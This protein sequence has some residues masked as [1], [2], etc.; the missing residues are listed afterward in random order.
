VD[1]VTLVSRVSLANRGVGEKASESPDRVA[2]GHRLRCAGETEA[3]FH[4]SHRLRE[5]E[6]REAMEELLGISGGDPLVRR[7]FPNRHRLGLAVISGE[8][9]R[10]RS[11]I[12]PG[13]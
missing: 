8:L 4:S 11:R 13:L 1:T 2:D 10:Q 12:L 9:E 7:D 5:T 6:L 3:A